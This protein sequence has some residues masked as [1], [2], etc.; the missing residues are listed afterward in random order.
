MITH[1]GPGTL[2]IWRT[3]EGT[4]N[5]SILQDYARNLGFGELTNIDLPFERNGII[6]DRE[7]FEE[8]TI[9]RPDL[10]RPE[11]WLGGDLMNLII[12]AHL[13]EPPS[14]IYCFR[15]VTLYAKTYIFE[16]VLIKCPKGTRSIYWN[17]LN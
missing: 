13:S 7:V 6:P 5:E 4:D 1:Q 2:K 14:E 10:V 16:D 15:D 17:G 9:S 11:G 12:G 3:Y 8:W